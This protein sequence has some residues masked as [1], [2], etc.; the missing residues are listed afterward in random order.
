MDKM[1]ETLALDVG[2]TDG[3]LHGVR[4]TLHTTLYDLMQAMQDEAGPHQEHRVVSAVAQLLQNGQIRFLA[5]P[6]HST[7][8]CFDEV[9]P[10]SA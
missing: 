5:Q 3:A 6:T 7:T 2:H 9:L 1:I 4:T 8:A 10:I